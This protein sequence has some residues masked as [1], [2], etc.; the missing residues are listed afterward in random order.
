MKYKAIIFDLGYTLF[1]IPGLAAKKD[2]T[3]N[4]LGDEKF[5]IAVRSFLRWHNEDMSVGDKMKEL[6]EEAS[7]SVY[8]I[9]A[10]RAWMVD[11]EFVLFDDV[12]LTLNWLRDQGYIIGLISNTPPTIDWENFGIAQFFAAVT[13]SYEVGVS[14]PDKNIFE[15][16]LR[17]L[18]L[19]PEEC[20]M[21]GDSQE[22]DVDGAKAMGMD[23]L[24]IDRSGKDG[25]GIG[26]LLKL[27]EY[28]DE[29]V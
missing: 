11:R 4:L 16:E 29:L 25:N 28:L 14:K 12:L 18:G 13:W 8:E 10:A 15:T 9:E 19:Q 3:K 5:M 22:K 27:N 26:S 20:L 2:V 6:A 24:L 17:K 21:I 1:D 7:F 23:G